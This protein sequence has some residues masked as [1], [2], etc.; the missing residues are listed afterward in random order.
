MPRW[1]RFSLLYILMIVLIGSNLTGHSQPED[2]TR[3][4]N[5]MILHDASG[6]PSSSVT[7]DLEIINENQFVGFQLDI[8]M[9]DGFTFIPGS[10]YLDPVRRA[11]HVLEAGIYPG[12]NLLRL[13]SVSFTNAA[14]NG[15]SGTIATFSLMAPAQTG[16]YP[17]EILNGIIGNILTQNILNQINNAT[18]TIS[19]TQQIPVN[20][21]LNNILIT[22]E[23]DTCFAAMQMITTV[24][25][26]IGEGASAILEAGENILLLP[27]THIHSGAVFHALIS[28]DSLFCQQF[29]SLTEAEQIISPPVEF[30]VETINQWFTIFPNPT[31]GL[32]T[33]KYNAQSGFEPKAVS[34]FNFAGTLIARSTLTSQQNSI[35]DLSSH[36]R[37][38]YVIRVNGENNSFYEKVIKH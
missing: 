22:S 21:D 15:N 31:T 32:L 12:T 6:L 26:T 2:G 38:M 4:A 17:L 30:S 11:N 33:I 35:I 10:A 23:T 25:F 13:L 24:D 8:P 3:G 5:I 36:P 1:I 28:D 37:G 18:I 16:A 7:I 34:V 29:R 27:E 9:N 20:L 19:E 14:F